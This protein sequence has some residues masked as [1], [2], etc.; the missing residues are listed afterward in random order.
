[1]G[2]VIPFRLPTRT[3][4][5]SSPEPSA[6]PRLAMSAFLA[7]YEAMSALPIADDDISAW[8][9]G[10]LLHY[11]FYDDAVGGDHV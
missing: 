9:S 10:M 6:K 4:E 2:E 7:R 1:M 5:A 3:E 11:D 8:V